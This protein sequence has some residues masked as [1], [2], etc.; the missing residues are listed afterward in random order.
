MRNHDTCFTGEG[1][2]LPFKEGDTVSGRLLTFSNQSEF[3]NLG[4]NSLVVINSPF[5][6]TVSDGEVWPAA[7]TI[8]K[9]VESGGLI[10]PRFDVPS[11]F[12]SPSKEKYSAWLLNIKMLLKNYS[13]Q[14]AQ[15]QSQ[16]I[17]TRAYIGNYNNYF[18]ITGRCM[19]IVQGQYVSVPRRLPFD[20]GETVCGNIISEDGSYNPE[21]ITIGSPY[22]G[23][24]TDGMIWPKEYSSLTIGYYNYA[25]NL[26]LGITPK[27]IDPIV[28]TPDA[29]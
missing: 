10:D 22:S 6:G 25:A 16:T 7:E 17:S 15:S 27:L 8:A 5:S 28:K 18:I 3:E 13:Y 2:N 9:I 24:V 26:V 4:S 20:K 29:N 21:A 19:R 1:N 12:I 23:T 14:P 11:N